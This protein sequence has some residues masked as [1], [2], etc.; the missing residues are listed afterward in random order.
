MSTDQKIIKNRLGV[1]ELAKQETSPRASVSRL[2]PNL[3]ILGH[4]CPV[5]QPPHIS[6]GRLPRPSA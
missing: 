4:D 6:L 3:N 5:G 2:R 1:L